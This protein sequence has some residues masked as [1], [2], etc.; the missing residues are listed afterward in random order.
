MPEIKIQHQVS[1][2]VY[3]SVAS[4]DATK[5]QLFNPQTGSRI[6]LPANE[7]EFCELDSAL[8]VTIAVTR[9]H[10]EDKPPEAVAL[11]GFRIPERG[12]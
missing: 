10:L 1:S 6:I 3:Q 5:V 8:I 4:V 9:A 11:E 12:N 7:Y 2:G